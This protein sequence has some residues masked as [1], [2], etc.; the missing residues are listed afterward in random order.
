MSAYELELAER[1]SIALPIEALNDLIEWWWDGTSEP[2]MSPPL[3]LGW[4]IHRQ[5]PADGFAVWRDLMLQYEPP[6]YIS[7]IHEPVTVEQYEAA[8]VEQWAL[9]A[10]EKHWTDKLIVDVMHDERQRG[11]EP[12]GEGWERTEGILNDLAARCGAKRAA[13]RGEYDARV[14]RHRKRVQRYFEL[15]DAGYAEWLAAGRPDGNGVKFDRWHD[16]HFRERL[17]V[18][19][20]QKERNPMPLPVPPIPANSLIGPRDDFMPADAEDAL[21]LDFVSQRADDLRYDAERGRWMRWDG[22]KWCEDKTAAAYDF[23]RQHIRQMAFRSAGV[24]AKKLATAQKVAAVE[25][26]ARSDQRIAV[27]GDTWDADP[28]LLNT[29]AGVVDLRTGQVHPSTPDYLMTKITTVTPGGECPTW[30]AFL[31]RSLAGDAELIGFVQRMLGYALTGDT[32]EHALFFL[33]GP[34]GNGKGVLLNTV[35]GILGE[36]AK[37]SPIET[38]TDSTHERHP[39]DLAGLRG[40]RLVTASETEKGR[41][42]AEAKIKMLTGGDRISA[43]F[44]RQDFFEFM[45]QFKLVISGNHKPGLRSVDEAIRRRLHLIPFTVKIPAAERDAALPEKLKAEWP[46][47]L[48]WMVEGCLAWQVDGLQPPAA[49]RAATDE[50]LEGEDAIAT[51]LDERCE[52]APD[53]FVSR[54]DLFASWTRWAELAREPVGTLKAFLETMRQREIEELKRNGV[55]GFRGIKFRDIS[56]QLPVCPV[57]LPRV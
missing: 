24:E 37:T 51:W 34:G 20:A 29:P 22:Q 7:G 42:W 31:N 28:M 14:Q 27:T 46:G 6:C 56:V 12:C 10:R 36:Y 26:L 18:I 8:L 17:E 19:A 52:R 47:I 23:I 45:P 50:Y 11:Y 44:M 15:D 39:T 38:F 21:A 2:Q 4:D 3:S 9:Y 25:K 43:R 35:A 55:R 40:A 53:G 5:W 54:A 48:A 32:R 13:V 41:R 33:F 57:P 49:V 30:L 1:E 16:R